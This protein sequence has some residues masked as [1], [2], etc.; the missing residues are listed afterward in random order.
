MEKAPIPPTGNNNNSRYGHQRNTTRFHTHLHNVCLLWKKK[1]G[2]NLVGAPHIYANFS[3]LKQSYQK[4]LNLTNK[5]KIVFYAFRS[6]L[7]SCTFYPNFVPVASKLR[8]GETFKNFKPEFWSRLNRKSGFFSSKTCDL[9][10][11]KI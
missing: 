1:T 11:P 5:L 8:A 2:G 6:S 7:E 9:K 4:T 10:G 3:V